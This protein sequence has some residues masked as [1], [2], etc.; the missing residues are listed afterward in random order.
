MV[1]LSILGTVSSGRMIIVEAGAAQL[2]PCRIFQTNEL[3]R[4]KIGCL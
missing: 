2:L 1:V 4:P 3:V